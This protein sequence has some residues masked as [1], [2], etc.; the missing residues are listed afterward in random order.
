MFKRREVGVLSQQSE[1]L[2]GKGW[3]GAEKVEVVVVIT[4]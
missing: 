4:P 1:L 3:K 2:D